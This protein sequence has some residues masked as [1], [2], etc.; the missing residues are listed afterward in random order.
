MRIIGIK[1]ILNVTYIE[2]AIKDGHAEIAGEGK[3]QKIIYKAVDHTERYADPE[4]QVRAEFWAELIYRY[5]YEPQRIGI[6]II[7]PDRTPSDRADIVV[8]QDD[9]RKRPYAVIE[10]KRD[11]ITDAEFNQAVEQAYGNGT[12]AKFRA[13]YVMVVA[14]STRRVLDCTDKYGALERDIKHRC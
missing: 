9:E 4:E 13:D 2:R 11:G 12:W 14:G 10:C 3:Q 8:F 5:Q 1:G 6:E 7:V